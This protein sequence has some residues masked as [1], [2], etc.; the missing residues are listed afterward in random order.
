MSSS[1]A[2]AILA[3]V[4][5]PR[6][7]KY[8]N[9]IL[10]AV[11]VGV[12]AVTIG[13][14]GALFN[15]SGQAATDSGKTQQFRKDMLQRLITPG[16][17]PLTGTSDPI[18]GGGNISTSIDNAYLDFGSRWGYLPL[19]ALVAI[20]GSLAAAAFKLKGDPYTLGLAV[21]GFGCFV[22]LLVVTFLEQQQVLIWLI[23]GGVSGALAR[24][25]AL[26]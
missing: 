5:L 19:L 18:G 7:A 23:V 3:T 26:R 12:L 13:P 2:I 9:L 1:S 25:Q 16:S 14:V 6:I 4:L 15:T 17:I 10:P 21:L 22:S 24:R 8:G 11:V 20:A